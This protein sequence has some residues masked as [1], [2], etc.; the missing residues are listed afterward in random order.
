MVC[1]YKQF[2]VLSKWTL[3]FHYASQC[4]R[5]LNM[6]ITLKLERVKLP[7]ASNPSAQNIFQQISN[8]TG[9]AITWE[10]GCKTVPLR[11]G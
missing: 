2:G 6:E 9:A 5:K 3:E 1:C 10:A 11:R 4:R 8:E 7:N